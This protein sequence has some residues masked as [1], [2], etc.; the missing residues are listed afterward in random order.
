[1]LLSFA[2]ATACARAG[3]PTSQPSEPT[4]IVA[5]EKPSI[6]VYVTE[7]TW[8]GRVDPTFSTIVEIRPGAGPDR[9][10]KGI[11]FYTYQNYN[12]GAML[13]NI[14]RYPGA[15]GPNFV[16]LTFE[17]KRKDGAAI[18]LALNGFIIGSDCKFVNGVDF[19]KTV[20]VADTVGGA[21]SLTLRAYFVMDGALV[22][23]SKPVSI[24]LVNLDHL[25]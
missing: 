16:M 13:K 11:N 18:P 22:S 15:Y 20:L 14:V 8:D 24:T 10:G 9:L 2:G 5:A 23:S 17:L 3:P 25:E 21:T 12:D 7:T 1:M 4:P 19:E 6:S